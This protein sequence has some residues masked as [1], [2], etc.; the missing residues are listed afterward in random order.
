MGYSTSLLVNRSHGI[1]LC[2]GVKKKIV[3]NKIVG[4][5]SLNFISLGILSELKLN[6]NR[7][8]HGLLSL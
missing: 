7:V 4:L 8:C 3:A 2:V 1:G 5:V 6:C